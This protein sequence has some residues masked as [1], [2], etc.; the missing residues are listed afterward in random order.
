VSR[1]TVNTLLLA[2]ILLMLGLDWSLRTDQALRNVEFLPDMAHAVSAETFAANAALAQGRTLQTPPDGT[3]ARGFKPIP[4]GAT[5]EEAARIG[6]LLV[7]PLAQDDER[8]LRRGADV[9]ATF[10][11]TCHGDRALGNAPVT[12][13]GVPPPPSLLA[14]KVRQMS[15]GQ[16][17][18]IITYG[19]GNMSPLAAQVTREDRW[20]AVLY[21][22][23]LQRTQPPAVAQGATP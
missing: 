2:A 19:Q 14:D 6:A 7:N 20:R 18:H 10:C 5:P 13:R 12:L 8:A 11:R 21:V 22:R 9:F 15:D 4:F 3:I 16:I 17:F 23:S 1:A